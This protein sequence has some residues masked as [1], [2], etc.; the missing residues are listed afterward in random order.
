MMARIAGGAPEGQDAILSD[1]RVLRQKTDALP[2]LQA[3]VGAT[4]Q[5]CVFDALTGQQLQRLD[6]Y[7]T[8]FGYHRQEITV[9]V[10]GQNLAAFAYFPDETV[11]HADTLWDFAEWEASLGPLSREMAYE[12]GSY[13]K[14]L[15][16][17]AL[18]AQWP[19]IARRADAR[20]RALSQTAPASIRYQPKP[21]DIDVRSWG[22]LTG[23]FFKAGDVQ[24]KHRQFSGTTSDTLKREFFIGTDASILLPYDPATDHV[25]LVEQFRIGPL[26]RGDQNPRSLEPIA[27]MIDAGETPEDTAHREAL[28]EAALDNLQLEKMFAVYASPGNAT[29]YFHCFLGL[30]DLPKPQQYTGGLESE[31][32][33]LRLHIIPFADAMDLITTGEAQVAPLVAML[34]WLDRNRARLRSSS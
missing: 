9:Q 15:N 25:L 6:A 29:D 4:A 33:D 30:C 10:A 7:E 24:V 26:A 17:D 20:L 18:R 3:A 31:A 14:P 8:P 28:E 21:G 34:L 11:A 22:A 5:G 19:M 23:Q 16:G 2:Y 13:S 12:I 1:H 32:E 27:G